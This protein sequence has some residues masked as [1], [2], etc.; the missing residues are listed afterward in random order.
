MHYRL[1]PIRSCAELTAQILMSAFAFASAIWSP[2]STDQIAKKQHGK[3]R[4][5]PGHHGENRVE[6]AR[7]QSEPVEEQSHILWF[8]FP[9]VSS[10]MSES[11]WAA[12]WS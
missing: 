6:S 7:G 2:K 1:A 4:N 9:V 12:R 10:D 5:E 3:G 8:T 11:Q